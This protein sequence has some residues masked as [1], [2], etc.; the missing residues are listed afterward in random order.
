[1][2]PTRSSVAS[3]GVGPGGGIDR[4]ART[5]Q[6]HIPDQRLLPVTSPVV[7]RP[8]GGGTIAQAYL[9]QATDASGMNGFG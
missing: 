1:M 6:R 7:N 8:G 5:L 3:V 2:E 4:T 9:N